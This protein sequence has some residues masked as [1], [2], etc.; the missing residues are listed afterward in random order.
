MIKAVVLDFDDTVIHTYNNF[1][2]TAKQVSERLG[3]PMPLEKTIRREYGNGWKEILTATFPDADKEE[4]VKAYASIN[5]LKI[6]RPIRGVN[7]ALDLLSKKYIIGVM[8]GGSRN[9][10]MNNLAKASIDFK[11]F[12]FTLTRDEIQKPKSHP[13]Y[14]NLAFRELEKLGIGKEDVIFVGD[15]VFDCQASLNANIHFVGVLTGPAT[16]DELE[17]SGAKNI[18]P[19]V[20]ELPSFIENNGF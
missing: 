6:Y 18:I 11:K 15:S 8:T 10:F 5:S 2:D 1:M 9:V 13:E 16:R 19:S 17:E 14:F 4:F 12:S 20:M 3:V 7:E